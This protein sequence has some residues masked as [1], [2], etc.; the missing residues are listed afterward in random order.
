MGNE[1]IA[2]RIGIHCTTVAFILKHFEKSEDPYYVNSKTGCPG[3][4]DIHDV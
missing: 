1:E 3:K 2:Q 4:M